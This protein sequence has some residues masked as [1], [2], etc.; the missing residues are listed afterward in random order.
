M[1]DYLNTEERHSHLFMTMAGEDAKEMA[2]SNAFT[3]EEKK[4]LLKIGEWVDKFSVLLFQRFGEAFKRKQLN[5]IR[6]NKIIIAGKYAPAQRAISHCAQEDLMPCFD[7]YR[8]LKCFNC[9]KCQD[10]ESYINCPVYAMGIAVD[11]IDDD[12]AKIKEQGCPFSMGS[13]YMSDI[14]LGFDEE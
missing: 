6:D 9:K 7:D 5:T 13:E 10:R 2:K 11:Y 4:A 12:G 8:M 1:R 3:P 14:D